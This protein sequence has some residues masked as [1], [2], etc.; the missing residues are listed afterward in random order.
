MYSMKAVRP[1]VPLSRNWREEG[2]DSPAPVPSFP[3]FFRM[4]DKDVFRLTDDKLH[5]GGGG[6]GGGTRM[7]LEYKEVEESG[8][9]NISSWRFDDLVKGSAR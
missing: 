5:R 9:C 4:Y 7:A 6:G 1:S 8:V 2:R 3:Y